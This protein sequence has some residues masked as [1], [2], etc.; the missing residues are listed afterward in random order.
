M[1]R[2]IKDLD[3]CIA[4]LQAMERRSELDP[5]QGKYIEAAIGELKWLR[6]KPH[7][8][9]QQAAASVRKIAECILKAF[10]DE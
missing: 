8:S 5:E 3:A 10:V 6:R 1:A 2:K 9:Q 4:E 7:L